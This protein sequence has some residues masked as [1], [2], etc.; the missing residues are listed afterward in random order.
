MHCLVDLQTLKPPCGRGHMGGSG[1]QRPR[2]PNWGI[3][4]PAAKLPLLTDLTD[5]IGTIA[6]PLRVESERAPRQFCGFYPKV[7]IRT[8]VPRAHHHTAAMSANL[9]QLTSS[10][11][12]ANLHCGRCVP[13][14]PL[15]RSPQL[16]L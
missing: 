4:C 5:R 14:T 1:Q 16:T 7:F 10:I 11:F 2:T 3:W 12:I 8:S 15:E 13:S 9:D 6:S